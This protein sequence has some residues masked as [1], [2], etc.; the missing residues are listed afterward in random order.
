MDFIK[1]TYVQILS[2]VSFLIVWLILYFA[3]KKYVPDEYKSLSRKIFSGVIMF[4]L[5][6]FFMFI[7]RF[8]SLNSIPKSELDHSVKQKRE[9]YMERNAKETIKK[10]VIEKKD[11]INKLK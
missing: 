9:Q 4:A 3:A 8:A 10:S 2:L 7:F 5:V 1:S 6:V 11:T